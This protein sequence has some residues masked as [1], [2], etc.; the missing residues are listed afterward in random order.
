MADKTPRTP[1]EK[2]NITASGPLKLLLAEDQ[3]LNAKIIAFFLRQAGHEVTVAGNGR[4]A[5]EIL[6]AGSFD[7][8]LMDV[9]MPVLDGMEALRLIRSGQVPGVDP[10]V[11]VIALTAH[12]S[13]GDREQL[14][15]AGMDD[16][17]SKPLDTDKLHEAIVRLAARGPRRGGAG[18][19]AGGAPETEGPIDFSGLVRK[20]SGDAKVV[21]E[22]LTLY[23][24]TADQKSEAIIL[25][26][27]AGDMAKLAEESHSLGGIAASFGLKAVAEACKRL[28][29][30]AQ[31]GDAGLLTR[32]LGE[33]ALAMART[34]EAIRA[35]L[36]Q[37]P[38]GPAQP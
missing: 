33:L 20:F 30:L 4:K 9:Q 38:Q 19:Q 31:A 36:G 32:A 5:L 7:L 16:Y 11:P 13:A 28:H 27:E 8:V 1:P 14:I 22:L 37:S 3:E 21:G 35:H 25:A 18:G 17:L 12:A 23:I 6:A 2:T 10:D 15:Q 29:R 26:A 24:E 34:G